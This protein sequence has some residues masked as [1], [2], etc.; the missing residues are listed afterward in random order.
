MISTSGHHLSVRGRDQQ[1]RRFNRSVGS[2]TPA[3]RSLVLGSLSEAAADLER[4]GIEGQ[5][6]HRSWWVANGAVTAQHKRG[7]QLYLQLVNGI[8]APVSV[9]YRQMA[10]RS[11]AVAQTVA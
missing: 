1:I 5:R 3:A 6:T 10:T 2:S 4:S 8:E 11:I 9:T 7:R